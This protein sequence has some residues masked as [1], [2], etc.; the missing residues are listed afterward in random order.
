MAGSGRFRVTFIL[1][2]V[3]GMKP[4]AAP[5]LPEAFRDLTEH[6]I[7]GTA[8]SYI[9][10]WEVSG[11]ADSLYGRAVGVRGLIGTPIDV[12]LQIDL[13]NGR[14]YAETLMPGNA[15]FVI[16]RPASAVI[17]FGEALRDGLRRV[18]SRP[19]LLLLM[20]LLVFAGLD[21]GGLLPFVLTFFLAH[22]AGQWLTGRQ[23]MQ[24]SPL[25]PALGVS[26][27][28]AGVSLSLYE[29]RVRDIAEFITAELGINRIYF[30]GG[31]VLSFRKVDLNLGLVYSTGSRDV[32]ELSEVFLPPGWTVDAADVNRMMR[33][34]RIKLVFGITVK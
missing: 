17:V 12:L 28:A 11:P 22:G 9:E 15:L 25:W 18:L 24:L 26:L 23:W 4:K 7:S 20:L 19:E 8:A 13:L 34:S 5:V 21:R 10:T 1:P 33:S 31:S 6:Q 16:P 14:S 32:P 30:S 2:I 27:L 3:N 29:D